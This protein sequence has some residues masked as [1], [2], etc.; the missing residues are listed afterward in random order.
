MNEENYFS[1]VFNRT[2]YTDTSDE[3]ENHGKMSFVVVVVVV[4]V[5]I[6]P[7]MSLFLLFDLL[8]FF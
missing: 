3:R 8:K 7:L 5:D 1:S 6:F 2:G 4:V